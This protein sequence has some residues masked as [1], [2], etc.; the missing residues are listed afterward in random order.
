MT[1]IGTDTDLLLL[2][3]EWWESGKQ[4]SI[5]VFQSSCKI[6]IFFSHLS[7]PVHHILIASKKRTKCLPPINSPS[8]YSNEMPSCRYSKIHSSSTQFLSVSSLADGW[9]MMSAV[10]KIL[11]TKT[12]SWIGKRTNFYFYNVVHEAIT[13]QASNGHIQQQPCEN[14]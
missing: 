4:R 1:E 2:S 12:A 7:V 14:T 6:S 9:T 10:I 13:S 3:Q 11:K 5:W 8:E